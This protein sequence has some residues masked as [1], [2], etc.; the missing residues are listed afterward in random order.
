MPK[1]VTLSLAPFQVKS[2]Y[3]SSSE[4]QALQNCNLYCD[5]TIQN[6]NHKI[7]WHGNNVNGNCKWDDNTKLSRILQFNNESRS[8]C[9]QALFKSHG[10]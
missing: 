2:Y 5:K 1:S 9:M 7:V 3:L 6:E 4:N 10:L 8:S